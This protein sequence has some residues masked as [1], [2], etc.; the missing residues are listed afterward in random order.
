MKLKLML[1]IVPSIVSIIVKIGNFD[2]DNIL[3]DEKRLKNI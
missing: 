2:S 3:I 1:K